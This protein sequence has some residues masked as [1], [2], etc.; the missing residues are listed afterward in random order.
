MQSVKLSGTIDHNVC[1]FGKSQLGARLEVFG[2]SDPPVN[3]LLLAG[4]HGTEP[5]GTLL[6]SSVLRS[7]R[8]ENLTCAVVLCLNPD[9]FARGTRGNAYGV[10][11]NRNFPAANWSP[12]PV[13]YHWNDEANKRVAISPGAHPASEPETQALIN[14]ITTLKPNH[15]ITLHAPLGCIDDPQASPLAHYLES[16]C[17]LPLVSD[18]GYATPGSLGSW[19]LEQHLH[20]ITFEL[21]HD[22]IQNIRRRFGPIFEKIMRDEIKLD[23]ELI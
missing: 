10:D 17:A 1:I 20:L 22:T 9:G 5:E 8:S 16:E 3:T 7:I 14:L 19:A 18:I 15:V 11:L 2:R 23:Q 4:Q 21:P 12:N 13:F 6:L